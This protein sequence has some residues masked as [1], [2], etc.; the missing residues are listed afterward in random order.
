MQV[1]KRII[2]SNHPFTIRTHAVMAHSA[3]LC[4]HYAFWHDTTAHNAACNYLLPEC[5]GLRQTT[6]SSC[7]PF[8]KRF[9]PLWQSIARTESLSFDK[10]LKQVHTR[11]G[12][13]TAAIWFGEQRQVKCST[14]SDCKASVYFHLLIQTWIWSFLVLV[15]CMWLPS[16]SHQGRI[17]QFSPGFY[18]RP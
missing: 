13:C 4:S 2:E 16:C 7:V 14:H 1:I 18:I 17:I 12:S 9:S 6:M 5:G 15:L 3:V 8:I 10:E 11:R